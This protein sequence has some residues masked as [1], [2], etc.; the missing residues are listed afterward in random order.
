MRTI[1]IPDSFLN[2]GVISDHNAIRINFEAERNYEGE[3]LSTHN[4]VVQYVNAGGEKDVFVVTEIDL[5]VVDKINFVWEISN[6][7]TKYSG[8]VSFSVKFY[9]SENN[10]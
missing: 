2:G 6:H 10:S 8:E 1:S 7:V 3:D 4:I 5:S 9:S